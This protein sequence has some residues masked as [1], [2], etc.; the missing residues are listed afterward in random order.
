MTAMAMD[1]TVILKS[2]AGSMTYV[3]YLEGELQVAEISFEVESSMR[4]FIIVP[5]VTANR[6]CV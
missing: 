5:H 1:R 4:G 6:K 2:V 3:G